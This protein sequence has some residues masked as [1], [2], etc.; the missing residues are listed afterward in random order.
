MVYLASGVRH[1][2]SAEFRQQ[3]YAKLWSLQPTLKLILTPPGERP[4][5]GEAIR[6]HTEGLEH[7][8]LGLLRSSMVIPTCGGYRGY[9]CIVCQSY[10]GRHRPVKKQRVDIDS[11]DKW[12]ADVD[13]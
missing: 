7:L 4:S 2:D 11:P 1:D 6:T 3:A 12:A 10:R 13:P 9:I 5:W 8:Q